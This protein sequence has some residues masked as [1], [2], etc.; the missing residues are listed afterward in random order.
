MS[1]AARD[2]PPLRHPDRLFID[3]IW[4]APSNDAPIDVFTAAT[5]ALYARVA[6]ANESDIDRAVR[7]AREAFDD[8]RWS[9][10][11][12]GDRAD[13]LRAIADEVDA[14][15]ED[16][17]AIWPNETGIL[18]S[19]ARTFAGSV[20]GVYRYYAGLAQDFAFQETRRPMTGEGV[21]LLVREPVGVVGAIIPWNGPISL[22]AWKLAPA[23][24][25]GCTVVVK[26]SP[27]APGH[28]LLMAEIV[29]AVGLPSG[30]VNVLTADRDASEALVR[31]P[32]IDKISFTGST[33]AGKRIGSVMAE[34]VG[35][36]TLELGGKSAGIVLD[37][38]DID[39]AAAVLAPRACLL[40]G[41]VCASISRIIVPHHRH[42][43]MV[44]ALADR[45]A[46]IRVGDPFDPDTRMGPLAT[47]IHRDRVEG[48]IARAISDGAKLAFGGGRPVGLDRGHFVEP[49]LF[50]HVDNR[51]PLAR[52]EVFGPVL[53]VIAARDE[54]HAVALANDS[55]FGLAGAVFTDD[56][57]R[58]YAVARAVRTGTVSQNAPRID[59]S[60]AFGGF[61]QSGIGREGGHEGLLSY[62]ETKTILLDRAPSAAAVQ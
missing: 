45:M 37:D 24:L 42:D 36:C 41:Q 33:A 2:T 53:A 9:G 13:Y 47:A 16:I 29:E 57:D 3:G 26:A 18:H 20:G 14:R 21:G 31:H 30:V 5:G 58:A 43:A 6:Q 27:E 49:T 62:L 15:A 54:T 61:K 34:R 46:K 52:E 50:G 23:L 55:D 12:H 8:G 35:R 11:S 51:S 10:L 38:Y 17:A 48:H 44:E 25:A 60:I 40:T 39:A 1:N 4:V 28:A 22:I 59:F 7:A 56:P 19:V 32:A